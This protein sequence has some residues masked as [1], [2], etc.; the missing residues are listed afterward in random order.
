MVS[1]REMNLDGFYTLDL[2]S[3]PGGLPGWDARLNEAV[4]DPAFSGTC[5]IA[6]Q[7]DG[8]TNGLGT[9]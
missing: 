2:S 5:R 9:A 3:A 6:T 4:P 8:S 7:A 1:C